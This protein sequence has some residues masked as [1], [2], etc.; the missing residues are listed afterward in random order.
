[1]IE[2]RTI[3]RRVKRNITEEG[4]TPATVMRIC[5]VYRDRTFPETLGVA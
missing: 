3:I 5:R 2:T 1:M 4:Q